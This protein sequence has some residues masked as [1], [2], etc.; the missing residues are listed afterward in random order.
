MARRSSRHATNRQYPRT[1]ALNELLREIVGDELVKMDDE[2]LDLVSVTAVIVEP[3]MRHA[4]VLFDTL[5]GEAG[6]EDALEAL[7]EVRVRLQAAVGRQ[8]HVKRVPQLAFMPDPSVRAG[9]RIDSI[10]RDIEPEAAEE[11]EAAGA[12]GGEDDGDTDG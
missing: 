3:D 6:D 4:T 2:R 7:A 10:L 8:A 9:E 12:D 1:A 11:T 5:D